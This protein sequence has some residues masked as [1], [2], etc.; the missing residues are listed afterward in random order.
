VDAAKE[1]SINVPIIVR[2]EG[3]KVNEGRKIL[4][5][6]NLAIISASDLLDAARKAVQSINNN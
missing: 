3:T 4:K 6:S 5:D 1:V 2:L